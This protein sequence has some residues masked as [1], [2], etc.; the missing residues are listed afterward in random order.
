MYSYRKMICCGVCT[1]CVGY[2]PNMEVLGMPGG[3][4]RAAGSSMPRFLYDSKTF[5]AADGW[6]GALSAVAGRSEA[7]RTPGADGFFPVPPM[8]VPPLASSQFPLTVL[9]LCQT[10][11]RSGLPSAVRGTELFPEALALVRAAVCAWSETAS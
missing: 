11:V 9:P 8:P 7:D 2:S 6:Y 1:I 4:H 10:P 3:R 5:W